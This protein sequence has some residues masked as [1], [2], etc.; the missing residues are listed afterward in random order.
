MWRKLGRVKKKLL[1]TSSVKR[2]S[3][4]LESK[5]KLKKELKKLYD[6]QGWEAEGVWC[7]RKDGSL[8]GNLLGPHRQEAVSWG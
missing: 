2:A 8:A 3:S 7:P 1:S 6:I 4:L 5:Q